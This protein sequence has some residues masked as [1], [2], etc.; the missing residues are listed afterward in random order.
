M[1]IKKRTNASFYTYA[2]ISAFIVFGILG[3]CLIFELR[4]FHTQAQALCDLKEDYSRYVA[5]IKK[6]MH[7]YNKTKEHLDLLENYLE[8]EK[9]KK[10]LKVERMS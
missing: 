1:V 10:Q 5:T 2:I 9:K 7:D 6:I 3:V 4:Y 8:N